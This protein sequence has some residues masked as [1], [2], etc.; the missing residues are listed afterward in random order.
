MFVVQRV[1]VQCRNVPQ[2]VCTM[3]DHHGEQDYKHGWPSWRE[4]WERVR[5]EFHS[6][7]Q[8]NSFHNIRGTFVFGGINPTASAAAKYVTGSDLITKPNPETASDMRTL[9]NANYDITS[10]VFV[11]AIS[12]IGFPSPGDQ[13]IKILGHPWTISMVSSLRIQVEDATLKPAR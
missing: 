12:R 5:D 2:L 4:H 10:A 6:S 8:N 11:L 9:R 7:G 3:Y 13:Y 1:Q